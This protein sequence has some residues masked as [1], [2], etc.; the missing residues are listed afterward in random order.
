MVGR[1]KRPRGRRRLL[2]LRIRRRLDPWRMRRHRLGHRERLR[3]TTQE[4]TTTR[5]PLRALNLSVSI[6][7]LRSPN[8]RRP[9]P[10]RAR[11]TTSRL[12]S[13]ASMTALWCGSE[14]RVWL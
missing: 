5:L 6:S 7:S 8:R 2:P 1:G 3:Q 13:T 11:G 12:G 4:T 9:S 10:G 14:A